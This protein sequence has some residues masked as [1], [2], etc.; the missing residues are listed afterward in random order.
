[1][2][3]IEIDDETYGFLLG[4]ARASGETL[5]VVL[6][7][8]LSL[9]KP[10][11]V[12]ASNA[13]ASSPAAPTIPTVHNGNGKVG[14]FLNSPT[15]LVRGSAVE[16]FLSILSWLHSENRDKFEKVLLLNGR[17]RRYFA[18]TSTELDAS[19]NSVM[20]KPVPNSPFWVITNSPTQLK[21]QMVEDV[22]RML[23]YDSLS[24]RAVVDT[25][26]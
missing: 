17:K 25:L 20:P 13:R 11:P 23:G 26:H 1:M 21:K 12:K 7:R 9:E 5:L 6:R 4:Q 2:R 14:A 10:E 16:K 24:T 8:L 22:M 15:Y 3:T 19:G 18:K